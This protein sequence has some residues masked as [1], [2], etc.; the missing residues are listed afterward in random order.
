[1]A[2]FRQRCLRH[3][4]A[5]DQLTLQLHSPHTVDATVD[6]YSDVDVQQTNTDANKN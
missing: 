4:D 6:N 1:M 5:T 3:G 2:R